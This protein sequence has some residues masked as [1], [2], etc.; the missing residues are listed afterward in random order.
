[1]KKMDNR[2]AQA[3]S[4][5]AF[6]QTLR[7]KAEKIA[8]GMGD[9]SSEG[10]Y[11]VSPEEMQR[12]HHE[13]LVHQIELE[14][15][16]DE[17]RRT[18]TELEE[19]RSRYLDLYNLAPVGYCTISNKGLILEANLTAANLLDV[20]RSDLTNQPMSRF[21]F[22]EDQDVY[23]L[24]KQQLFETDKPQAYELRMTKRDGTTFWAHVDAN[25]LKDEDGTQIGRAVLSD[26]TERKQTE[27]EMA[28]LASFPTL[29]PR[30]I[31][32]VDLDG[33]ILYL[34]PAAQK[35]L[36]DLQEMGQDHSW[37]VNWVS[38]AQIVCN[39]QAG[40]Y[41]RDVSI[42]DRWYQQTIN[43]V[44]EVQCIRIYGQ[45][46]T[47]RK[48]AEE[49]LKE[50]EKK[51]NALVANL[52]EAD[53]NKNEFLNALSHELRNPLATIV[54]GLSLLELSDD[55][56]Q[57]RKAQDI[58]QRQ[59][60]QLCHLVD[61]LLDLTRI[62]NNKIVLDKE[63]VDLKE[64]SLSMLTDSKLL[65]EEKGIHL[66]AEI[67]EEDICI[68]VDPVRIK[69]IIG[70]LLDNAMKFTDSGGAVKVSVFRE[71][72]EAV[73][74]VKD[75][76]L[77]IDPAFLSNLFVP[78]EQADNSLDRRN[79]GLGLGLSITKGIAELHGGTV[80]VQSDGIGKGAQFNIRLPLSTEDSTKDGG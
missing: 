75:N 43:F 19:A 11:A 62:T 58:M 71:K 77:G 69:Q 17:L 67:N 7:Q 68:D 49:A 45:D 38:V 23:Y 39:S 63:R 20:T 48:R 24:N 1:M 29:D 41:T 37:L 55:K 73:I 65:F 47:E 56:Q 78:F 22:R 64:L 76:G 14:M 15:Q 70:N 40:T 5:A 51:A 46:I 31:V 32:E 36:P 4:S 60:D 35:L 74:Y 21:I 61:D 72:N 18:Q 42:G 12:K 9:R 10:S 13:L 27:N 33:R 28:R 53:K 26:I 25:T 16:N 50:S 3:E 57:K 2:A 79:G 52:E 54:A 8:Q 34:N 6:E 66:E 59:I 80:S 30:P 44:P